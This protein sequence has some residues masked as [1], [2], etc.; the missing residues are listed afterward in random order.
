MALKIEEDIC[1]SCG[2]CEP[3]CPNQAISE[4][5]LI[6]VIDSSKCTECIEQSDSSPKCLKVCPIA[7]C[8][9]KD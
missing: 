6:Y 9:L 4:D 7:D 5:D 1:T 2:L 8:I 3:V